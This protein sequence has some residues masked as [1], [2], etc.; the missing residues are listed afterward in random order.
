[1]PNARTKARERV[2]SRR[3]IR[4]IRPKLKRTLSGLRV[5]AEMV[6]AFNSDKLM[7]LLQG[8]RA[9]IAK[10]Q[11]A[12][13]PVSF[14]VDVDPSGATRVA[15]VEA[16][17]S[18]DGTSPVEEPATLSPELRRALEAA[19]RRGH[20]RAAEILSGEDMLSADDFAHLIG[21]S[22]VTVNTKRLNGQLLGLDGAK[23]GFRFPSWQLNADGKPYPELAALQERLGGAWPLYRFLVQPH[24]AL[25]GLTG[26]EALEQGRSR[27][28]LEAAEGIARGDFR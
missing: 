17:P 19:R 5:P 11:E 26:R 21:T 15:P 22:R 4:R 28:V 18:S 25:E 2:A 10:S 12:R 14:R 9:A 8:Y 1:M 27:A 13:R 23:R 16:P 7:P 6:E 20:A 3:K 24:G